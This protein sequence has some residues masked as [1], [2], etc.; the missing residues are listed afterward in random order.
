MR[1]FGTAPPA[2]GVVSPTNRASLRQDSF[3]S[4]MGVSRLAQLGHGSGAGS[5]AGMSVRLAG[6]R[7]YQ[8]R[9]HG[10]IA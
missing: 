8:R 9:C 4:G 10:A 3:A 1:Q 6:P 2:F 7:L 5:P